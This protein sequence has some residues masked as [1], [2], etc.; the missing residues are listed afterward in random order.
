MVKIMKEEAVIDV[1]ETE[2]WYAWTNMMP[3]PSNNF[4]A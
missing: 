3:P 1:S 4:I 2:D